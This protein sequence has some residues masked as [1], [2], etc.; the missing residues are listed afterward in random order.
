MLP[1]PK[2]SSLALH[3]LPTFLLIF[4]AEQISCLGPE[5]TPKGMDYELRRPITYLYNRLAYKYGTNFRQSEFNPI[6]SHLLDTHSHCSS[7]TGPFC[8]FINNRELMDKKMPMSPADQQIH[9]LL[10]ASVPANRHAAFQIEKGE[11]DAFL[12]SGDYSKKLDESVKKF[13]A[14]DFYG[15]VPT[16][17]RLPRKTLNKNNQRLNKK[18]FTFVHN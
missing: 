10:T 11:L 16:H 5:Y 1:T 2:I 12:I 15:E 9:A 17:H 6:L 8:G 4:F 13:I 3:F 7:R 14:S 18:Q